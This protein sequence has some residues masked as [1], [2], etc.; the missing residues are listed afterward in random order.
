MTQPYPGQYPQYPGPYRPM[1][2][3]PAP[4]PPRY[5]PLRKIALVSIVLMGLTAVAAVI[6]SAL[7]W[8]SYDDVKRFVYG[9]WRS[10]AP[11]IAS[12]GLTMN[13]PFPNSGGKLPCNAVRFSP[14]LGGGGRGQKEIVFKIKD[15]K[16]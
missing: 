9:F 15:M 10:C 13:E 11:L 6:Q 7:L 14:F 16:H 12:S 8:S 3:Q 4:I 5:R 2:Y 1:P